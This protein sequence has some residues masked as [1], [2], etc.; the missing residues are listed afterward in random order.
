MTLNN[1]LR[2]GIYSIVQKKIFKNLNK[3]EN[4][5]EYWFSPDPDRPMANFIKNN[6]KNKEL[7][8]VEIGTYKG[9]NAYNML[10]NIP[11]LKMLYLIDPYEFYREY[12]EPNELIVANKIDLDNIYLYRFQVAYWLCV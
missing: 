12:H 3:I 1:S 8:G 7:I 6:Y 11:N 9:S 10:R 5:F 4:S 2:L